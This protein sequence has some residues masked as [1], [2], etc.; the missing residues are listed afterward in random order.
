MKIED[1]KI[2]TS[3]VYKNKRVINIDDI[4]VNKI[5]V[6]NMVQRIHSNTLLDTMIKMLLDHYA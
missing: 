4:D 1:K 3:D 6:S 2:K 5:L